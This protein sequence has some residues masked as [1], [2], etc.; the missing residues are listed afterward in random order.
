MQYLPV[1]VYHGEPLPTESFVT[2]PDTAGLL[3]EPASAPLMK[4]LT[5]R[6]HLGIPPDMAGLHSL[7]RE[8]GVD[9]LEIAKMVRSEHE[10]GII[11]VTME[12]YRLI[13][14][15]R[16]MM[17]ESPRCCIISPCPVCSLY[18]AIF[19]EGTGKVIQI[20][21]CEPDPGS[22]RV[23]AVFSVLPE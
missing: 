16:A 5:E 10:T 14:G 19:A 23:T 4:I 18:A 20:E 13:D 7:V 2:E 21:R 12:E 6:E 22:S 15:C 9:V 3:L 1:S 11:T 8:L 17:A